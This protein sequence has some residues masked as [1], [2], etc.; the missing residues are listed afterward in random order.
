MNRFDEDAQRLLSAALLRNSTVLVVDEVTG[1][2]RLTEEFLKGIGCRVF[3][4]GDLSHAAHFLRAVTVDLVIA[5][6]DDQRAQSAASALR[7]CTRGA[8]IIALC[9]N[10][11]TLRT[12]LDALGKALRKAGSSLTLN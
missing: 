10:E 8:S 9:A 12:L 7:A 2:R 3:S 4:A 5:R 11:T 6:Y 1:T